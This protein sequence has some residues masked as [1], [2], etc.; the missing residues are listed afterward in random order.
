MGKSNKTLSFTLTTKEY[1]DFWYVASL[2]NK[3]RKKEVL[4]ELMRLAKELK[5]HD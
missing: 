5:E 3:T 1:S 2:I 4:L